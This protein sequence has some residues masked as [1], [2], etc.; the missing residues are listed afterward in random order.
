MSET[1]NTFTP[2]WVQK[3]HRPNVFRR[4]FGNSYQSLPSICPPKPGAPLLRSLTDGQLNAR[5][6]STSRKPLRVKTVLKSRTGGL[7]GSHQQHPWLTFS[8]GPFYFCVTLRALL[9]WHDQF[10]ALLTT[11]GV[12]VAPQ[13]PRSLA[14]PPPSLSPAAAPRACFMFSVQHL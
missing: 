2:Y 7:Q 13:A 5:A 12:R 3:I 6:S 8:P 4:Q 11:S 9:R 1:T 10:D 14:G